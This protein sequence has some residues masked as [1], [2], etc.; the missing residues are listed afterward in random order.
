M[1]LQSQLGKSVTDLIKIKESQRSSIEIGGGDQ[2]PGKKYNEG[3]YA[4][5]ENMP[6]WAS[7]IATKK[8]K[9]ILQEK[10]LLDQKVGE[11][12]QNIAKVLEKHEYEYMQAYNV[13]VKHK[14]SE[15]KSLI[16]KIT[17]RTGD[18][19]ANEAKL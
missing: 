4:S 2:S 10:A 11:I 8:Y 13:F 12:D 1:S 16:D 19:Q 6:A 17:E 15:V 3:I 7:S 14:E 18:K 5:E 9:E